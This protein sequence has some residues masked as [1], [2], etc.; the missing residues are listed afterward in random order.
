MER[1]LFRKTQFP[2]SCSDSSERERTRPLPPP[3]DPQDQPLFPP[4][5]S[6]KEAKFKPKIGERELACPQKKR[7]WN[8][9]A[10][11]GMRRHNRF[12]N[13]VSASCDRECVA[14]YSHSASLTRRGYDRSTAL[15][16]TGS[17]AVPARFER[18]GSPTQTEKRR[19]EPRLFTER[20][21]LKRPSS[22]RKHAAGNGFR[23][24]KPR[25]F[26]ADAAPALVH[27][28]LIVPPYSGERRRISCRRDSISER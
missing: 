10:R 25:L 6:E 23:A 14:R 24:G 3:C 18:T 19:A 27:P 4:G 28:A 26:D 8:A 12:L 21:Q 16:S 2:F 9:V 11:H 1:Y 7:T 13:R 15:Q 20:T 17:T 22:E 5:L